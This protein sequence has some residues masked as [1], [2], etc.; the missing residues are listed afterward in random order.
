MRKKKKEIS[1]QTGDTDT[2]IIIPKLLIKLLTQGLPYHIP[3]KKLFTSLSD[4]FSFIVKKGLSN[5]QSPWEKKHPVKEPKQ[6]CIYTILLPKK[7]SPPKQKIKAEREKQKNTPPSTK[8][9][10]S[11]NTK[12]N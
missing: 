9:R 12:T 11:Y 4:Q 1:F 8:V 3:R 10:T 7:H 2:G 5:L 6:R